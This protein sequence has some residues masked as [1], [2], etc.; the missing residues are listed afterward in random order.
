LLEGNSENE[1]GAGD[2]NFVFG[3]RWRGRTRAPFQS[4]AAQ[5]HG[6]FL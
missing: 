2:H 3:C 5:Q 6:E 4:L 1:V